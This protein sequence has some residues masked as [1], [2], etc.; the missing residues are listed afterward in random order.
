MVLYQHRNPG[1]CGDEDDDNEGDKS[2][3][4]RSPM[5]GSILNGLPGRWIGCI[6]RFLRVYECPPASTAERA[7][8]NSL[9]AAGWAESKSG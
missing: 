3:L 1:S 9:D 5:R 2:D 8:R 6:S 7:A 4:R